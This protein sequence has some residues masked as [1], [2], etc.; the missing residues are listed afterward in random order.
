MTNLRGAYTALVTPFTADGSAVDLRRLAGNVAAQAAGGV[1]GVVPCGTTGEAPTLG[2]REHRAVVET[3]IEAARPLGLHVMAGAGS[4]HTG[5]AIQLHRF[6]HEA[7]ADSAL[8][9][10]PY[11]NRPSQE[12]LFRHFAAIADSC[13]LPIVLYNVPAR[14][15]VSLSIE[16]IE[17][18]AE[19]PNVA[20]IKEASGS[21]DL[22][23]AVAGRTSLALLSGDDTLTLPIAAVGGVG[24]VSVVANLVPD[25]IASLCRAVLDGQWQ[26]ARRLHLET[27]DLARGMLSLG[28]NPAPVKAAL[29]L[30]QRDSGALRLPLCPLDGEALD[31]VAD[32]L[33]RAGVAAPELSAP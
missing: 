17:R 3:A 24:V 2:D 20:G 29:R 16:T 30:L 10:T 18:L 1:S 28:P 22:A 31:A 15:G 32:L 21:L 13:D 6:A 9:V 23:T 8:H 19:H 33:H 7:G 25:K 4:Y 27:F 26:Q 14:T 12:G 5:R 11:Y